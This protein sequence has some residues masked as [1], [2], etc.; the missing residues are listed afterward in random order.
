MK[1]EFENSMMERLQMLPLFQ[2]MANSDMNWIME[3]LRFD[4]S[5]V[6]KGTYIVKQD[7]LCN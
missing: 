6:S 1:N 7:E 3:K 5:K 2:G 4:F